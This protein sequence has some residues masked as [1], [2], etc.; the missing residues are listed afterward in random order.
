MLQPEKP[1]EK[2][3]EAMQLYLKLEKEKD[4]WDEEANGPY[5]K[6]KM[7]ALL[8]CKLEA[9]KEKGGKGIEFN[10]SDMKCLYGMWISYI[11]NTEK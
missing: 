7:T 3:G 6:S 8:D 9:Y 2:H 4:S 1:V 10:Q 5:P 11:K